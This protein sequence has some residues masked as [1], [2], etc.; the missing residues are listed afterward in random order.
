MRH[1]AIGCRSTLIHGDCMEPRRRHRLQDG[2]YGAGRIGCTSFT[3]TLSG[4]TTP[5]QAL[6]KP[7]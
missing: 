3:G 5:Y 2:D 6:L 1:A 4:E 7:A